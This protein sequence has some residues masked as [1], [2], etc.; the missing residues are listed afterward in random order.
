M[1]WTRAEFGEWCRLTGYHLSR[2]HL[3]IHRRDPL[4][5][6]CLSNCAALD[7]LENR[8][9]GAGPDKAAHAKARHDLLSRFPGLPAGTAPA[10][11]GINQN[12]TGKN[13][14]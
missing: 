7:W 10:G 4:G 14:P 8:R 12:S 2:P 6:Y 3:D 9:R 5:A 13:K 11:A 1:I